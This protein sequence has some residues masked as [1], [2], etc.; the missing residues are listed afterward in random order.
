M[1]DI[2]IRPE[3]PADFAAIREMLVLAFPDEDVATLVENLR[4][5]PGYDPELSFVAEADGVVAGH[6]MFTPI[7]INT[8][9]GDIPAMTLAPLAVHPAWQRQGIGS[10]LAQ[11]GLQVCRDMGHRIVTVIGHPTYYPRFGFTQSRPLGI[12]MTHARRDEA[13]MVMELVPGALTGVKGTARLPAVFD[14]A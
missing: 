9:E 7:V 5:T 1:P 10:Q 11:Y 2:T 6:V 13:K 4:Q 14:E 12:D 8:G 3:V